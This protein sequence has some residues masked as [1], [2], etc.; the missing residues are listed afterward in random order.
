[1]HSILVK[2][3]E[4]Y[5]RGTITL[6]YSFYR[7]DSAIVHAHTRFSFVSVIFG[8]GLFSTTGARHKKQR[9]MLNPV[10]SGAHMR[11]LTPIFHTVVHRVGPHP[12]SI[13]FECS[14]TWDD[15]RHQLKTA[16]ETRLESGTR[17]LDLS[18]W[19]GRTALELVGQ[20]GL[21]HSFDPLT[22]DSQDAYTE[23]VKGFSYVSASVAAPALT[24]LHVFVYTARRALTCGTCAVSCRS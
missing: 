12:S 17:E 18:G 4:S 2:D 11:N 20:G 16:V 24:P 14:L 15:S 5:F 19:M 9:K 6:R 23:A 1:M 3:Q 10:F 22:S 13:R 7:Y 8:P 21:G